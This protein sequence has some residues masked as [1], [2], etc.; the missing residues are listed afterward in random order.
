[1]E[2]TVGN[3]T[4]VIT[5]YKLLPQKDDTLS[6]PPSPRDSVMTEESEDNTVNLNHPSNSESSPHVISSTA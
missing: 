3:V 1:M 2:V 5:D 4:V 6:P